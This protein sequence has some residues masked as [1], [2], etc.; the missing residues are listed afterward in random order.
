MCLP[1]VL[2]VLRGVRKYLGTLVLPF[3]DEGGSHYSLKEYIA[4]TESPHLVDN[5]LESENIRFMELSPDHQN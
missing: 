4:R 3:R 5:F 1:K 2:Y